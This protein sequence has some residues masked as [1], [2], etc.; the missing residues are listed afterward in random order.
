MISCAKR[1]FLSH[2]EGAAPAGD[3]RQARRRRH[4][5]CRP[6]RWPGDRAALP[7]PHCLEREGS[8]SACQVTLGLLPGGGGVVRTVRLLGIQNALMG[9][10]LQGTQFSPEKAK[11]TGLV[12]EVVGTVEES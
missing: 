9:V 12:N 10:L 5:R 11:E 3:P 7:L 2:E 6:R 8:R 4:Q 1:W